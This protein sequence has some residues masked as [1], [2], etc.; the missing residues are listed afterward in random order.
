MDDKYIRHISV[1]WTQIN[2]YYAFFEYNFCCAYI[3][4]H[5]TLLIPSV[6]PF[7]TFT[8]ISFE[9]AIN[10]V[11]EFPIAFPAILGHNRDKEDSL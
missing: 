6:V 9:L 11:E 2:N 5:V 8:F 1:T 7:T 3:L 4:Y 10:G